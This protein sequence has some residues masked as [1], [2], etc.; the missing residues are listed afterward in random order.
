VTPDVLRVIRLSL[1]AASADGTLTETEREAILTQA[2]A[3]G[4]EALVASDLR[5]PRR[6]ADLLA[7]V[8][9][10]VQRAHLY[11]IAFAIVRADEAVTAPE[12]TYL[13]E[14]ADALK[15]DADTVARLEAAAAEQIVAR[16]AEPDSV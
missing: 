8:T 10:A 16:A 14:V 1:S 3:V 12:R 7:D 4:A 9:D 15:L 6:P 13:T 5:S 2:R 11:S